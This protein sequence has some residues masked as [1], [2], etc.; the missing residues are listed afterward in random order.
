M[1]Y[2]P[3]ADLG[4]L[5]HA[6]AEDGPAR[7]ARGG[8]YTPEPIAEYLADWAISDR[9]EARILDPSC[10]EGVFLSAA[11]KVLRGLGTPSEQIGRQ[12]HGVE[13]DDGALGEARRLLSAEDFVP[14]FVAGD[15]FG[16]APPNGLLDGPGPFDAVIGNPPYV[17]YQLHTGAVRRASAEAALRQGVRLSGL[18][19]SWAALLVHAGSFLKEDGRLAMVL[20]AELLTVGYAEP[21]RRWLRQRFGSVTL[22]LFERLQFDDALA[23]VVLLLARGTGGCDAF[24]LWHARGGEDLERLRVGDSFD[25]TPSTEGKWTDLLVPSQQRQLFKRIV[26]AHFVRLSSYG[27]P[28]LGTVTGANSYFALSEATR[29]SYE[30]SESQLTPISPPGT[31]HLRGLSFSKTDW[32]G[33]R[34]EQEPVWM[35]WPDPADGSAALDRYLAVGDA[36]AVPKAYKCRIRTPWWRPPRS[37]PPDLFFTYMSHRYPRLVTNRAGVS[38]LNSMHGVRLR[39]NA[40]EVCRDALPLLAL[41]SVTMLG[42]EIHGRSYGGGVLKM[43]P[44]EAASLPVPGPSALGAAWEMLR[45]EADGLDRQLRA[46]RWTEVVARVDEV[47]LGAVLGLRPEDAASIHGAARALR[48]RRLGWARTGDVDG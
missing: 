44:S 6:I 29:V 13:I 9:A 20:P 30:L 48:R 4:A 31:R 46:G 35:L 24:S 47:L 45:H 23:N 34:A 10:G 8:F 43:E 2:R 15:F 14:Q 18:A 12:L 32:E 11:A 28:E 36:R 17:R 25:V 7:K 37:E 38:F 5:P 19:S 42:A 26:E 3:V 39:P 41:N 16:L 21:I 40:P 33:L 22:I 27:L 1:Y